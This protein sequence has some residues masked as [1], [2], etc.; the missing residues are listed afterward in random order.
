MR[1]SGGLFIYTDKGW[2]SR[3]LENFE[4]ETFGNE[5]IYCSRRGRCVAQVYCFE[6]MAGLCGGLDRFF[7]NF[8]APSANERFNE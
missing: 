3:Q 2:H 8:R 5:K 1:V 7:P 4:F 6:T